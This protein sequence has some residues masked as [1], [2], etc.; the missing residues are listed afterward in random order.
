MPGIIANQIDE[1]NKELKYFPYK[2]VVLLMTQ[3]EKLSYYTERKAE[4]EAVLNWLADPSERNYRLCQTHCTKRTLWS[5]ANAM[6]LYKSNVRTSFVASEMFR[7]IC[8]EDRCFNL[9]FKMYQECRGPDH[10]FDPNWKTPDAAG[11]AKTMLEQKDTSAA[12]ILADALEDAGMQDQD[13]LSRLRTKPVNLSDWP[14]WNL[15]GF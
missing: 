8:T 14:V 5:S 10:P 7:M 4:L 6:H 1:I 13:M 2:V 15:L 11:I 3:W 9:S 12:P